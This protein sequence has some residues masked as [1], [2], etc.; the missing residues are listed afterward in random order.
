VIVSGNIAAEKN[1]TAGKSLLQKSSIFVGKHEGKLTFQ[2]VIDARKQV[3]DQ[4]IQ[5]GESAFNGTLKSQWYEGSTKLGNSDLLSSI[6]FSFRDPPSAGAQYKTTDFQL[7]EPY[8]QQLA[9]LGGGSGGVAWNETGVRSQGRQT[10]PWPGV[11]KWTVDETLLA[12]EKHQLYDTAEGR[13][14]DRSS[15]KYD[16][17]KLADW[18]KLTPNGNFKTII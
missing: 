10:Y 7:A 1:V 13:S 8:W 9:R 12:Y 17:P 2:P 14:Q 3:R 16:E 18:K 4:H 5:E 6:G 11:Q 15:G